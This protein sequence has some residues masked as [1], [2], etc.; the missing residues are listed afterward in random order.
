LT[1]PALVPTYEKAL[2]EISINSN[3]VRIKRIKSI[4]YK[5]GFNIYF[6]KVLNMFYP[7]V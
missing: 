1:Y 5:M 4:K 2:N 3:A 6:E 7:I